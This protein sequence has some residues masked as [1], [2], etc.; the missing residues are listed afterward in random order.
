MLFV[1]NFNECIQH[2]K[3]SLITENQCAYIYLLIY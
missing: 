1:I 2:N 3:F